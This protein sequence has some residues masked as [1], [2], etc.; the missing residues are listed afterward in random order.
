M[1]IPDIPGLEL[2]EIRRL[3]AVALEVPTHRLGLIE[4]VHPEVRARFEE[5]AERRLAGEPLQY[6]EGTVDF[7]PL[8]LKVDRRALI[9][10]PETEFMWDLIVRDRASS[11]LP[12]PKV[13]VDLCTG[14]GNLALALKWALPEARVIGI[15]V[16]PA[17]IELAMENRAQTGLAVEFQVGDLF[18]PIDTG[19]RASIDL[20][21]SNPPYVTESE[22]LPPEVQ[23]HEPVQALR[24]GPEGLDV[25]IDIV[26]QMGDWL[27]PGG[28]FYLEI[29]PS[30]APAVA[31][32][33]AQ[34]GLETRIENDQ[35]GRQRYAI[36]YHVA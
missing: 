36:G 3:M 33:I 18:A 8:R 21:V 4:D 6:I 30:Q 10:R 1:R 27:S 35:S 12:D 11:H 28:K 22:E 13:V 31:E 25:I 29:S 26:A 14:S 16:S 17:A 5:L 34:Q 9:P 15:D 32:L 20:L 2:H 7:G 19:L 23:D 24:A